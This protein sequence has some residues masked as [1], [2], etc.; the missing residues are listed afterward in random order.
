MRRRRLILA[1]FL[2][3]VLSLALARA[4][5]AASSPDLAIR[6]D[7]STVS[8]KLGRKFVFHTTIANRGR[9]DASGLIAHLNVLSLRSNV[10][11][12]PEDWS[13][14]RTRYLT[15]LAPGRSTTI[16]WRVEA[17]N[18]GSFGVYVAVVPSSGARTA[19]LTGPLLRLSVSERK[20]LNSGG[21]LPLALGIPGALGAL[22]LAFRLRR[23]RPPRLAPDSSP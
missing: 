18:A 15:P 14:R 6:V 22:A 3:A 21:I 10:Y 23:G 13:S 12:D 17:V 11:V 9:V 19:P 4:G 5:R 2:G 7:R 16:T 8:T 20:T 1:L